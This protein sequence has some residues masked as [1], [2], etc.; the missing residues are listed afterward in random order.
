MV[1]FFYDAD[2]EMNLSKANELGLDSA[3]IGYI[4][5]PYTICGES[6]GCELITPELS[7]N[8]FA[9]VKA[10]N[11]P[12]TSALNA[13]EYID[14]FEPAF[15]KGDE[16]FYV[17]FGSKMSGTFENLAMA[18]KELKAKYP[19]VKFTRYDTKAISMGTGI[20]VVAAYKYI[21]AGKSVE[22]TVAMLDELVDHINISIVA[23][24]LQY[25]KRGGRLTA[26]KALL[27][28]MLQLKPII[29]LT[30]EGTLNPFGTVPGRNK[31]I[32]TVVNDIIAN[33]TQLDKHPIVLMNAACPQDAERAAA[34]IK[35][36]RPEAEIWQ[37]DVG[38]VIGTHCGPGTLGFCFV[39][40]ER[41]N[42][43]KE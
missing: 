27:G 23:D 43:V 42:P 7:A 40:G 41:P 21:Q 31:A 20:A 19:D 35:A 36:A 32:L 34:R 2:S 8:F 17:S 15:R 33:A 29:K 10:G 26:V 25:L 1:Q 14:I 18:L 37:F 4:K 3:D 28:T 30:T 38:P 5:M 12:M 16:I 11:M 13:Q 39:A 9:K 22:E 24:D 6:Q